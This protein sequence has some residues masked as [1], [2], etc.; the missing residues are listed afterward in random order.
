MPNQT[1]QAKSEPEA[2]IES[3]EIEPT[4][5]EEPDYKD[6]WQR[7][8]AD[9][10]NMRKRSEADRLN[11]SRYALEGFVE[12]LLP[13]VDNFYRATEHVPAELQESAWVKGVMYIQKN[14]LDVLERRGITEIP[15]NVGDSFDPAKHESIG[16]AE[17]P[18]Q[19]DDTITEVKN[20]GY[21]L[22][23]RVLRPSQ[24]AAVQRPIA[25]GRPR[26][27]LSHENYANEQRRTEPERNS[28]H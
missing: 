26:A 14:M 3:T 19:A 2:E 10:E 8:L 23:E 7:A 22:H 28:L 20:K 24:I 18:D 16:T 9:M 17:L 21:M 5:V 6:K 27:V 4:L 11:L 1:S 13:V 15:A 25:V 12:E